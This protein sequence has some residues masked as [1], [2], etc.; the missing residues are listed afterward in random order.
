MNN[1]GSYLLDSGF[2]RKTAKSLRGCLNIEK[3]D[4]ESVFGMNKKKLYR[5]RVRRSVEDWITVQADNPLQAEQLAV[6]YPFVLSV[7]E[8]SA[9]SGEKPVGT[10]VPVGIPVEEDE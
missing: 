5:V 4:W 3:V 2:C 6:N 1:L 10:S 9:I 8:R 7:F